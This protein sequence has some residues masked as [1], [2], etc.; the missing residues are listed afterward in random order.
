[1][2]LPGRRFVVSVQWHPENLLDAVPA[3]R[4]LFEAFVA[5]ATR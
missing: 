2:E 1:M 5:E 3:M 4:R